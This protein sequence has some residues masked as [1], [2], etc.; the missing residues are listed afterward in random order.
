MTANAT[1][2][3]DASAN[4]FNDDSI[5]SSEDQCRGCFGRRNLT[6]VVTNALNH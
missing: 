4:R 6:V 2:D 3:P 5:G 1:L